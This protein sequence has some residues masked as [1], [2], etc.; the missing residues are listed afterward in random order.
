MGSFPL[1]SGLTHEFQNYKSYQII[2]ALDSISDMV[3]CTNAPFCRHAIFLSLPG[4]YTSLACH[5]FATGANPHH[6]HSP[7]QMI[8]RFGCQRFFWHFLVNDRI[9][10]CSVFLPF[11]VCHFV[12]LSCIRQ[13]CH[14]CTH[15][16]DHMHY[17]MIFKLCFKK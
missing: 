2:R 6:N 12:Q 1:G 9:S 8:F 3:T 15:H 10:D 13:V 14:R 4:L 16:R 17:Q 11:Q 7:Y 5:R